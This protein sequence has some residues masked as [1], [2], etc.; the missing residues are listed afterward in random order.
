M[1]YEVI[2]NCF[3]NSRITVNTQSRKIFLIFTEKCCPCL[4]CSACI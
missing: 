1:L 4:S 2:T 3:Y